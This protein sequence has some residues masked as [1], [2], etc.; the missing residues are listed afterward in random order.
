MLQ[1]YK[2]KQGKKEVR[3]EHKR[4][5]NECEKTRTKIQRAKVVIMASNVEE[6]KRQQ[7]KVSMNNGLQ[8]LL[9]PC[10][11]TYILKKKLDYLWTFEGTMHPIA[12]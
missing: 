12:D 11:M 8:K 9:E 6:K 5:K 7:R 1:P 2:K 3:K 10:E 4:R